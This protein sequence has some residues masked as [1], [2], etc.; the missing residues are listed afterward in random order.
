MNR[1]IRYAR[2]YDFII[3]GRIETSIAEHIEIMERV[4]IRELDK[5]LRLLH[6]HI[7]ASPEFVVEPATR[8]IAARHSTQLG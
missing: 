5:A 1:R 7:G 6:E 8:A 4:H 3:E 2:M